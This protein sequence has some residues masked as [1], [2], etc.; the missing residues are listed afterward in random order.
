MGD[1][2]RTFTVTLTEAQHD[3]LQAAIE[4][5]WVYWEDKSRQQN[6]QTLLR[7]SSKLQAAWNNGLR[8]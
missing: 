2:E 1:G 3:V 8:R 5:A 4:A 7:A 6:R